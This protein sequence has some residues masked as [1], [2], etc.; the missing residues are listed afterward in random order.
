MLQFLHGVNT[1]Q[2][3]DSNYELSPFPIRK[4]VFR[5]NILYVIRGIH[6]NCTNTIR[7]YVYTTP[8]PLQNESKHNNWI[9]GRQPPSKK[10]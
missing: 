9:D 8:M 5:N 1:P 7:N 3:H 10:H 4:H 2:Y 6:D